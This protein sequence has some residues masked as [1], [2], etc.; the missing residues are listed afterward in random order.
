MKNI[1]LI[2]VDS[3]RAD[4]LSCLGYHRETTPNLDKL[5][6]DGVLFTNAISCGPDTLTS[7]VPM[8]FSNYTLR[9]FMGEDFKKGMTT[10]PP[11]FDLARPIILEI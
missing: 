6:K 7:M 9:Y 11:K 1:V 3:L 10:F 8:L 2:T 4:H 5:A